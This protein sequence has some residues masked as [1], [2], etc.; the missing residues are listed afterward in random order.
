[1]SKPETVPMYVNARGKAYCQYCLEG[2]ITGDGTY[3]LRERECDE[4]YN[5]HGEHVPADRDYY[6]VRPVY[7]YLD[8]DYRDIYGNKLMIVRTDD[9][10]QPYAVLGGSTLILQELDRFTAVEMHEIIAA[11]TEKNGRFYINW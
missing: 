10:C 11:A 5:C 9:D 1:M 4:C 6:I 7:E 2:S 8:R 3:T